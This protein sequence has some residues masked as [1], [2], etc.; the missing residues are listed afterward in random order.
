[1]SGK[2][3]CLERNLNEK[4]KNSACDSAKRLTSHFPEELGWVAGR[5]ALSEGTKRGGETSVK[6]SLRT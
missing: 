4:A 2:V 3:T 1:M 5:E 6:R